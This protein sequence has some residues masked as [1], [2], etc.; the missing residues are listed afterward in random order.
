MEMPK[1]LDDLDPRP[2]PTGVF[3]G[4][5]MGSIFFGIEVATLSG[6]IVSRVLLA[7]VGAIVGGV[8]VA[9]LWDRFMVQD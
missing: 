1:G 6:G 2:R 7:A 5:I 9:L 8:V 4:G 3:F